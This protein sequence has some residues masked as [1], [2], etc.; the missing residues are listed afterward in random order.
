MK[1]KSVIKQVISYVIFSAEQNAVKGMLLIC[2]CNTKI[3]TSCV[4]LI[5]NHMFLLLLT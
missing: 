5:F 2:K 3:V 1:F 4:T